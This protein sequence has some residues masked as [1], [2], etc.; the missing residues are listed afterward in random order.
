[1][2]PRGFLRQPR[3][4]SALVLILSI[5]VGVGTY[6]Y[7]LSYQNRIQSSRELIPV[8]VA[9]SEIASGS[10][11]EEIRNSNQLEIKEMP[12]SSLPAGVITPSS[13]I[14]A[15]LKTKGLLAAGQILVSNY[16]VGEVAPDLGLPIPKGMLAI[17][18]SVDDVSRVGNFVA[19]GSKVVVFTTDIS[20]SNAKET[21]VFLPEALVLGIGTQ[22]NQAQDGAMPT[23]SSLVTVALYPKDAQRLILASKTSDITFALA[24]GNNPNSLLT[25]AGLSLP[26]VSTGG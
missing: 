1:M 25:S 24:Y 16:F 3:I 8:Y 15:S 12:K 4:Q 5:F 23:P 20:N 10:S 22:T 11:Y 14:D 6:F 21:K 19:P 13:E 17:T 7:L 18:I 26:R 2:S 9:S